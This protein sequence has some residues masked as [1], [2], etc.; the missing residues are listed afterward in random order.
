MQFLRDSASDTLQQLVAAEAAL[1]TD[2][3]G[4]RSRATGLLAS[5]QEVPPARLAWPSKKVVGG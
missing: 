2:P 1:S 3:G 4:A 5:A